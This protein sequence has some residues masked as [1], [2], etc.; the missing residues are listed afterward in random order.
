MQ[1]WHRSGGP[2]PGARPRVVSRTLWSA[3]RTA[4]HPHR[5]STLRVSGPHAPA[6]FM[7]PSLGMTAPRQILPGATYLV[8]RRCSQRQFLLRPSKLSNQLVGYLL[9][10]AARRYGV[11]VHA[12]CVMSN[13]LHLVLTDPAAQLPAFSQYFASLVARSLNAA[14]GR[15]ESF[16]APASYSAVTL[17]SPSDILDKAAYVL[18]NPVA[19]GLVRRGWQWPGL[20]SAPDQVGASEL[21]FRRPDHFFRAKGVMPKCSKLALVA[22]P[23]FASAAEFQRALSTALAGREDAAAAERNTEGDGFLGAARVLAQRPTACPHSGEPRRALNP[24]VACRDKWK[25]IEV[26]GRLVEFLRGYRQALRA[27]RSGVSGVVFPSGTYLVRVT[28]GVTCAAT[29]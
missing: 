28:H 17:V 5:T 10:V 3:L 18:A 21:E 24:R 4:A 20:C 26:L 12:F 27:W 8:T 6:R 22:P 9:A 14:L 16:W 7:P 25:R 13:H 23:G 15:S 29:V 1:V 11:Q 19:A 2:S